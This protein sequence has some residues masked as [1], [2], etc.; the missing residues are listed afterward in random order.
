MVGPDAEIRGDINLN[1][2]LIIY[3]KVYGSISSEGDIRIGKSEK[4]MVILRRK[5]FI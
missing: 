2:G 5:T 3:G 1:E 4:C